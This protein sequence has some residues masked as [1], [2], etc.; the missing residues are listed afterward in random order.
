MG[1]M[2]QKMET[3]IYDFFDMC[4]CVLALGGLKDSHSYFCS[5]APRP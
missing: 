5:A 1:I 4:G 3:T 2:E